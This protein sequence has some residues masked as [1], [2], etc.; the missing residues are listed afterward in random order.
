MEEQVATMLDPERRD[1]TVRDITRRDSVNTPEVSGNFTTSEGHR[2]VVQETV[3]VTT[4]NLSNTQ[5]FYFSCYQNLPHPVGQLVKEFTIIDG[6]SVHH[7]C[8]FLL[9]ILKI[10][11]VG[12]I[13]VPTIC[14]LMYPYCKGEA[15]A[16]LTQALMA[17]TRILKQFIPVRLFSELR[18]E[19]YERVQREG[20]SLANYILAVRNAAL[21]LRIVGTE[22]QVVERIVQGLTP[23]QRAR[24]VFQTPPT[25]YTQLEQLVIF[26]RNIT[27]ADV[28]RKVPAPT[29][30]MR[31]T[32]TLTATATARQVRVPSY[33]KT[34]TGNTTICFRCGTSEH[35]QRYCSVKTKPRRQV[36]RT[37]GKR[38]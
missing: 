4:P 34:T 19:K 28:T 7:L 36:S 29:E 22:A 1:G 10:R 31:A 2:P 33:E 3:K 20:E 24:F 26:D 35:I 11:Q 15:L 17:Y 18:I 25:N 5:A 21:I 32:E 37:A 6:C 8:D 30:P 38:S 23:T 27:F 9:K 13:E 16:L 14:E 12:L